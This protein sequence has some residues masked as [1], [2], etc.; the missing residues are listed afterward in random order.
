MVISSISLDTPVLGPRH[1]ENE[2]ITMRVFSL[3]SYKDSFKIIIVLLAHYDLEL[4]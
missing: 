3:V 1:K 4:H 2:Y